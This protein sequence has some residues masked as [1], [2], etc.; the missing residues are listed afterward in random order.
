ME[1]YV[2]SR[3]NVKQRS[4][5]YKYPVD[6]VAIQPRAVFEVERFKMVVKVVEDMLGLSRVVV[7]WVKRLVYK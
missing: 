6:M 4:L 1:R 5:W 7:F 2:E 3:N